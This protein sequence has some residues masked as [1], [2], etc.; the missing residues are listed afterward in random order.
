MNDDTIVTLRQR[1]ETNDPLTE[2][3]RAGHDS[4]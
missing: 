2:V 4:F 3:L 1:G